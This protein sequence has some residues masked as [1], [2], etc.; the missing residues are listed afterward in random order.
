MLVHFKIFSSI[1]G[2]F[3]VIIGRAEI[4]DIV[5]VHG[6][7]LQKMEKADV[8]EDFIEEVDYEQNLE[9]CVALPNQP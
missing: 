4:T 5:P 7:Q 1:R 8:K 3:V 9:G 6:M 2:L